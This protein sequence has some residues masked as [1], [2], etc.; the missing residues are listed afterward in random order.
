M[1]RTPHGVDTVNPLRSIAIRVANMI[2][3]AEIL[4]VD[5]AEG[6]AQIGALADETLTAERPQP[7]GLST[8][9]P[10]G[11]EAW[12]GCVGGRRDQAVVLLV[13]DRRY[14]LTSLAEGEVALYSESEARIVLKANGDIEIAPGG[15]GKVKISTDVEVTGTITA[16]TDVVGG[17]KH[18]ATHTHGA[19]TY[20]VE[21]A[22]GPVTAGT[23]SGAPS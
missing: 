2:A 14:T 19:G 20:A 12:I 6:T 4:R 17:G 13:G 16:S 22:P 23:V 15:T 11:A 18:L 10:V 5:A 8:H 21:A 3:R 9:P 7:Y 1:A